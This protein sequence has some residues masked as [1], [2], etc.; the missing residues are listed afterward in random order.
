VRGCDLSHPRRLPRAHTD[1]RGVTSRGGDRIRRG[2]V[3]CDCATYHER[4]DAVTAL[5][6]HDVGASYDGT[7][8]VW[9]ISLN[10]P[11]GGWLAIVGPNGAGKSTLLKAITGIIPHT[12][13]IELHGKAMETLSR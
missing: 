12:G 9:G 13:A 5:H 11:P 7:P 6:L 10:L 4:A 1:P 3:L 2:T 8:V